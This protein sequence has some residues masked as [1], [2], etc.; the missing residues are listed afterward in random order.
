M[1]K[2]RI[3][4]PEITAAVAALEM[5]IRDSQGAVLA[6]DDL[7][8]AAHIN[9]QRFTHP[10]VERAP[11]FL[12]NNHPSQIIDPAYNARGFHRLLPSVALF[13]ETEG[14]PASCFSYS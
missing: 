10:D 14:W 8:V 3:L 5:C 2:D 1:K 12:G 9:L 7:P 13:R 6:E 11:D 4:N